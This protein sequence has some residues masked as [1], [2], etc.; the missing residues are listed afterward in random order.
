MGGNLIHYPED[1]G[2]PMASL[3]LVKIL[4][5]SVISTPGARFA[6]ADIA[7]FYLNTPLK[8]PKYVKIRLSD[9]PEEVTR[10]YKLHEIAT[11][12]GWVYLRVARGMYG[13]PQSGANSHDE[14]EER[15]NKEDYSQS[16]IVPGLWRHK[17]RP[18][19]VHIDCR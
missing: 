13:L 12:D 1:V 6:T 8:R 14:L 3:L 5:N 11:E 9:I 19:H 17:T 15:L 2:T 4:L 16:K 7:N 18:T 10:E